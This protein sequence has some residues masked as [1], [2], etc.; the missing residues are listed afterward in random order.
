[1]AY[2]TR[3]SSALEKAQQRN[4]ALK[5]IDPY[6]DLGN[7]LTVR[8]FTNTIEDTQAKVDR[9]NLAIKGLTQLHNEMMEGERALADQHERMLNGVSAKFGRNSTEYEMAGGRKRSAKRKS[10]TTTAPT[11]E[12]PTVTL[13]SS[14]AKSTAPSPA[15]SAM[16][17]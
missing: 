6:L 16:M 13:T 3:T 12:L 11:S 4:L 8:E 9:Y 2:R 7:G 14:P 17:N 10:R 15:L 1:M 5:S